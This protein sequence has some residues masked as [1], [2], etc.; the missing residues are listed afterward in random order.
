MNGT[1]Y[2][3]GRTGAAL[4]LPDRILAAVGYQSAREPRPYRATM[5]AGDAERRL[6]ARVD[7]GELDAAAVE[8]VLVA[9][10][11]GS[12]HIRGRTG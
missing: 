6:R 5:S 3:R 8:A 7:A 11:T 10:D 9:A 12:S 2:P 4:A 1:G